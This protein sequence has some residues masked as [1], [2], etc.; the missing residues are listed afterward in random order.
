MISK[1]R[2][3]SVSLAFALMGCSNKPSQPDIKPEEES[4]KPHAPSES[5]W[6][7]HGYQSANDKKILFKNFTVLSAAG[8]SFVGDVFVEGAKIT[9]VDKSI[10]MEADLVIQG[11][12]RYLTPGII[13][14]HSHM[15]VYPLPK[16]NAHQDGNE[17]TSPQTAAVWSENGVW[18]QDPSFWRALAGGVTTIQVLPGSANLFGGRSVVLR[19]VP[20]TQVHDMKFAGAPQGLKMACGENPKRV[21]GEKGGPGSRMG[22]YAGYRREFQKAWEYRASLEKYRKSL[23]KWEKEGA[24]ASDRPSAPSDQHD[25]DTLVKVLSGDILVHIHCYRADE[26]LNM[27]KLAEAY[28]FEI[29]SFHH[30]LEAYKIA[31]ELAAKKIAVSTW[32]DWW[33]FKMEAFDGIPY[34]LSMTYKAGGLP[35]VHSDSDE[36]IRYLNIEAAKA[37][38]AGK[39]IGIE[40]DDAELIK[41]LTINPAYALGID[42]KV[43]SIEEGKL[44]DLVIWDGS[45]F[46][47]F[48][49]AQQVYIEGE[50]VLDRQDGLRPHSDFETGLAVD[51]KSDSASMIA[52]PYPKVP[53]FSAS[54]GLVD[55]KS[56]GAEFVIIQG[57]V[58]DDNGD[59]I[60]RHVA[61]ADG[62]I[63]AVLSELEGSKY[64]SWETVDVGGRLLT[65]GFIE[66]QTSLGLQIVS[67]E[68]KGRDEGGGASMTPAFDVLDAV[69]PFSVHIPITRAE[70]VTSVV[71]APSGGIVEGMG[72]LMSLDQTEQSLQGKGKFMFARLTERDH[73]RGQFWLKLRL[74]L[75]DAKLF[76]KLKTSGKSY[77]SHNLSL[78]P[79]HLEALWPVLSG[80]VPLIIELDRVADI[81]AAL[82]FLEMTK[83]QGYKIR[84]IING[85]SESWMVADKLA[86]AKVPVILKPT[87]QMPNALDVVRVRD[88]LAG[89]LSERGVAVLL[90]AD[91]VNVRRLRQQAGRAVAYGMNY[92]EAIKAITENVSAALGISDRGKIAVGQRAD[93][94]AW[95]GDPL[96][97]SGNV[98]ALWIDGVSQSVEHRQ[99]Q[100]ARKYLNRIR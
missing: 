76:Q 13:D 51:G 74:A 71:V 20:R 34:N 11:K 97:P 54:N 35:V 64:A 27:L 43:G 4:F 56:D 80:D 45:P 26:M 17:M 90:T 3:L 49:K 30:A 8:S 19:T 5:V 70:G 78:A 59:L 68:P 37:R 50:K 29:R 25:M 93:L 84:L 89:F 94:V 85:G 39:E 22:N 48:S 100:L 44:A 81:N 57:R 88:D 61:V 82:R 79:L 65:P 2:L 92:S 33:G 41:W 53:D 60:V 1:H 95:N 91:D 9:K 42:K 67:A 98:A 83:K 75:E 36:D 77:E 40:V 21:Y 46:S 96:Q 6:T 7:G 69:D 32:A 58:L 62:K 28:G 16:A 55:I 99:I 72:T 86:A 31:P 63:V 47:A 87:A 23:A 38:K 66:V 52:T 12:G 10:S 73:N 18:P 14:T 24:K 15:G